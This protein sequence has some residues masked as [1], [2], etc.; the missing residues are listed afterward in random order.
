MEA[1]V[2][3]VEF[4]VIVGV[5]GGNRGKDLRNSRKD[6]RD[7]SGME[8]M[9]LIDTIPEWGP[10]YRL[11][12]DL[13]LNSMPLKFATGTPISAMSSV[14]DI[15]KNWFDVKS[16][17]CFQLWQNH[18]GKPELKVELPVPASLQYKFTVKNQIEIKKWYK[19]E[20]ERRP[21]EEKVK[22]IGG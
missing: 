3:P 10:Y 16:Y 1:I 12:F 15:K 9:K 13:F 20:L 6:Q 8:K 5:E 4:P 21:L 14:L 19:I 22:I 7:W 18:K 2:L 17:Q 11:S